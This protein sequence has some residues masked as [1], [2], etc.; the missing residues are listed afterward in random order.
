VHD[1]ADEEHN[2]WEIHRMP[3]KASYCNAFYEACKNDFFC[4]HG[5]FFECA[6]VDPNASANEL[7]TI[8]RSQRSPYLE[9]LQK[10]TD[11]PTD[12]MKQNVAV[13]DPEQD[14]LDFQ[15]GLAALLFCV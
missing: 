11:T 13:L 7:I 6:R 1:P 10:P 15:F 2:K 4:G 14:S 9:S 3:I 12:L 8:S 5:N